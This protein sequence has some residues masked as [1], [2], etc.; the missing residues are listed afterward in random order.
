MCL[1]AQSH[2]KFMSSVQNYRVIV[3]SSQIDDIFSH[4]ILLGKS[5]LG[6]KYIFHVLRTWLTAATCNCL[7]QCPGMFIKEKTSRWF[8]I[9]PHVIHSG[10]PISFKSILEP[11]T[12]QTGHVQNRKHWDK[13]KYKSTFCYVLPSLVNFNIYFCGLTCTDIEV[14]TVL[15]SSVWISYASYRF[16]DLDWTGPFQRKVLQQYGLRNY[17]PC[18]WAPQ[19]V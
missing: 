5:C 13:E 17:W 10:L 8:W 2:V 3:Y 19:K 18:C 16:G 14:Y 12:I 1:I 15:E 7:W 4:F 9:S 11:V 6:Q